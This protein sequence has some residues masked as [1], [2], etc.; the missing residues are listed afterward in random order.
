MNPETV[1]AKTEKGKQ[2][3]EAREVPTN[4][5][6]A[7]IL[8]DGRSTLQVLMKNG[9]GL[10]NLSDSFEMLEEMGLIAPVGS[11]EATPVPPPPAPATQPVSEDALFIQPISEGAPVK[12]PVSEGA[13]V[14]R[15]LVVLAIRMLGDKGDK[16]SKKIE[17]TED[18]HA[19]LL[20][21][22]ETCGKVIKLTIDEK[23]AEAFVVAAKE[24][25]AKNG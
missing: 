7:L 4:L 18:S 6:Y 23:K 20:H 8:V 25:M 3:F 1:Y 21:T 5:R 2:R 11:I 14:K 13:P 19:A 10:E 22:I 16:I 17:D 12:R 9:A 24:I 15:L